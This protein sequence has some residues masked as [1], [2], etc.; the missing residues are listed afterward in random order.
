ML[1]LADAL[2]LLI[3]SP[4]MGAAVLPPSIPS[5][6]FPVT[7]DPRPECAR[8]QALGWDCCIHPVPQWPARSPNPSAPS[9]N[10]AKH[11]AEGRLP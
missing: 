10:R 7:G 2:A 4:A 8:A 3:A 9:P 6:A 1:P 11:L 5:A